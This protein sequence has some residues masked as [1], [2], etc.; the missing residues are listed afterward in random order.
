MAYQY[1]HRTM[2][3]TPI[4][5]ITTT[6]CG[7]N[8]LLNIMHHIP[9]VA[10]PNTNTII[11]SKNMRIHLTNF[12]GRMVLVDEGAHE[13]SSD[14]EV[15]YMARPTKCKP[16]HTASRVGSKRTLIFDTHTLSNHNNPKRIRQRF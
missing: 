14:E 11:W 9:L 4:T 2:A 5:I 10:T 12:L 1:D 16:K 3:N 8:L 6:E 7:T 13:L 15:E